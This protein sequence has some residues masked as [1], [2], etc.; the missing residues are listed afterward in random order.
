MKTKQELIDAAIKYAHVR[1]EF[2]VS[3]HLYLLEKNYNVKI[4]DLIA[5]IENPQSKEEVNEKKI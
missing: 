3:V 5:H 1:N 2:A 4:Q